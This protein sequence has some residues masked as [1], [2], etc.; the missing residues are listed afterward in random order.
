MVLLFLLE[1]FTPIN[2]KHKYKYTLIIHIL[3]NQ[4]FSVVWKGRQTGIFE[5][6]EEFMGFTKQSINL[7]KHWRKP[8][9][10]LMSSDPLLKELK[11]MSN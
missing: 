9:K 4:K 11:V 7:S 1:N 3:L 6:W 10:R 2:S 8:K 5:S